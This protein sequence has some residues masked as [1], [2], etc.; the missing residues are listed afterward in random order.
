MEQ[1]VLSQAKKAKE[2]A[3]ILYEIDSA[4]KNDFL[5]H[6]ASLLE[7]NTGVILEANKN[8][9]RKTGAISWAMKKRLELSATGLKA[10]ITGV[11][12][13]RNLDNPVGQ[14]V[15]KWRTPNNL[16]I[17]KVR[18]PIGVIVCIFESRPNV[19]IDVASLS[20]K[21][22][23]AVI[24][25]G[26]EEAIHTNDILVKFVQQALKESGLPQAAVQQLE[27]REY[28]AVGELVQLDDYIDV[29]IPR[30]SE[31]LINAVC[32]KSK[33]PVLKHRRGLCH[34][35]VDRKADI[36]Q[37]I[38][39]VVNA[40]ASNPA[41]CN[42]IET[43]LIHKDIADEII[44]ELL[45]QL[46]E[47]GVEVRGCV[48]T[49]LYHS[50]CRLATNED[51]STEYLDLIISIKVVDSFQ[52]AIQHIQFYSSGL[53]DSIVTKD[54]VNAE[55]F[56]K[57]IDSAVVLVNASNRFTDGGQFGFGAEI[58]ISTA[59]IHARGPIGLEDLTITKYLV[60]GQGQIRE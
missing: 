29:V 56:L 43:A 44:P 15:K 5:D 31:S 26:G 47:I 2:A 11:K 53:S 8:D 16:E 9:L 46:M 34:V 38:K 30:G 37:A 48:R 59:K 54:K 39:I 1:E 58:G 23:N 14:V 21:S 51:W 55:H 24:V 49:C 25:R 60:L 40:K 10:I 28:Q 35:Y 18:V 42:A 7:K 22:G 32:Q 45:R 27:K 36:A 17:K 41:T 19:V 57:V 52:E 4:Q 12:A 6:L 33:V 13:I 3:K 20:V 50:N